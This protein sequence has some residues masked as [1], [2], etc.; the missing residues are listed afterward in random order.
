M[1]R[2]EIPN[3]HRFRNRHGKWQTYYRAAGRKK[4]R[5]RA[6]YLSPEFWVEYEAAK[7]CCAS[8]RPLSSAKAM[9][10]GQAARLVFACLKGAAQVRRYAEHIEEI[11]RNGGGQHAL[12][13][14]VAAQIDASGLID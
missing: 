12:R 8:I 5:L 2:M 7:A 3:L 4:L 9:N 14:F 11:V 6:E 13:I 10:E 1:T